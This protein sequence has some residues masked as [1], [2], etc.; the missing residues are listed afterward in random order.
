MNHGTQSGYRRGCR[1]PEC[2][3]WRREASRRQQSK[4]SGQPSGNADAAPVRHHVEQQIGRGHTKTAVAHAAGVKTATV[5]RLMAGKSDTI[6]IAAAQKLLAVDLPDLNT[7]PREWVR[8]PV[9]C[10]V[11]EDLAWLLTNGETMPIVA[12]RLGL[13]EATAVDH[14]RRYLPDLHTE[15]TRIR[16]LA[17]AYA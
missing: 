15:L 11:C 4:R 10:T 13:S 2:V 5:M 17:E 12:Q 6:R 8:H 16:R 9:C 3:G 14:V 7:A 1:C